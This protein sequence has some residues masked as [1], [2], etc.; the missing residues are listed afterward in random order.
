M[1]NTKSL[2]AAACCAVLAACGGG[3]DAP[4]AP[5]PPRAP[6]CAP[7]VVSVALLGD[8]TMLGLELFEGSYRIAPHNPG[9]QLQADMDAEFGPGAVVVTDY[10]VGGTTAAQ[11]NPVAADIVVENYGIN[12]SARGV[13]IADFTTAVL[14]LKPTLIE[15]QTPG[16]PDDPVAL[17]FRA[18]ERSLGLPVADSAAYVLSLPN[19]QAMLSDHL[20]P[21]DALYVLIVDNVLAPAVAK[22]VAP[23]RCVAQQ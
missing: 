12:D 3:T 20:H 6:A 8:S 11:G 22:Q 9:V 10:G 15:T 16:D 21:T 17:P 18:A 23:L 1:R 5:V 4:Q 7:R 14:T 13:S 19:Y 2:L